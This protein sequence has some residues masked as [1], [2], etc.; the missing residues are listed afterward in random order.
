MLITPRVVVGY[1][2]IGF[3]FNLDV[4][5][6]QLLGAFSGVFP[7]F[8]SLLDLFPLD[9]KIQSADL[10][11]GTFRLE[12][13][14]TPGC[15]LFGSVSANIPRTVGVKAIQGPN[16]GMLAHPRSGAGQVRGS[17]GRISSSGGGTAFSSC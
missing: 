10:A 13:Q 7:E 6:K 5:P 11:V 15:G 12:A 4:P 17:S 8:G 14:C 2:K 9:A 16:I 3:T 1:K